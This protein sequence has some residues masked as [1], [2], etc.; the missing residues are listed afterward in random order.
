MGLAESLR[1]IKLVTTQ[2][3]NEKE[4][5]YVIQLIW[6]W[7]HKRVIWYGQL[8]LKLPDK[9]GHELHEQ[10][11]AALLWE[12]LPMQWSKLAKQNCHI[13][14]GFLAIASRMDQMQKSSELTSELDSGQKSCA[15]APGFFFIWANFGYGGWYVLGL[16]RGW[17]SNYL[18]Q[19]Q[20]EPAAK[21][22]SL[23]SPRHSI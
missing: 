13:Y 21:N 3:I 15:K 7:H 1:A 22:L 9:D 18:H 8:P 2:L 16:P 6:G 4:K 20:T 12:V 10:R 11:F 23:E 14:I 19:T 5:L 17:R